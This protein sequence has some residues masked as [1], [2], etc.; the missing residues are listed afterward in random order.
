MCPGWDFRGLFP[1]APVACLKR[2]D[3]AEDIRPARGSMVGSAR[4]HEAAG[5][6][7]ERNGDALRD[8]RAQTR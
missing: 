6:T 3:R 2:W 1:A 8:S 5:L 7:R 4:C